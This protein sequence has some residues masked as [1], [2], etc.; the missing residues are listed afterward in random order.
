MNTRISIR[1][2][3]L[4][5]F[6]LFFANCSPQLQGPSK[7][8]HRLVRDI[9]GVNSLMS[10]AVGFAGWPTK[11]YKKFE[12]LM[13]EA[14]KEELIAF[15]RHK[16]GVVRCY[17]FWGLVLRKEN[18]L[19]PILLERIDDEKIVDQHFG[20]V[21]SITTVADFCILMYAEEYVFSEDGSLLNEPLI[22]KHEKRQL[23]SMILYSSADIEYL[24]V[25]LSEHVPTAHNYPR[26][27]QLAA[28]GVYSA[29]PALARY[30]KSED[31]EFIFSL[32][33]KP[34]RDSRFPR[35]M[36]YL[37]KAI[38]NYPHDYFW[39]FMQTFGD[40]LLTASGYSYSWDDFYL[41]CASYDD[42][43]SLKVLKAPFK[44]PDKVL[45]SKRHTDFVTNALSKYPS[46]LKKEL[47]IQLWKE[48]YVISNGAFE[49]MRDTDPV[50]TFELT[51][52]YLYNFETAYAERLEDRMLHPMIEFMIELDREEAITIITQN[53]KKIQVNPFEKF[54]YFSKELKDERF[55]EPLFYRIEN[56]WN[57]HL[58]FEAVDA[59]IA[60]EDLTL[61]KKL[62]PSSRLN[63]N[64][65]DKY[66]SRKYIED[67]IQDRIAIYFD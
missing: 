66:T 5:L 58:F 41:A 24:E 54:A 47:I 25:V 34:E 22:T 48:K 50:S 9:A 23:D 19:F 32:R 42:E 43:K 59:I 55:L 51:K 31:L 13:A 28:E 3:G 11:Q 14:T 37:F 18:G 17:A 35:H 30:Q 33:N 52:N 46:Q 38:E 1:L 40:S 26:I 62:I 60:F 39:P 57:R 8:V 2:I 56:E 6:S 20:C 61:A 65:L 44:N 36:K 15:T 53:L 4:V 12:A 64:I 67:E 29:F 10:K 49:F 27:K 45:I 21:R 7:R 16:N 63:Q